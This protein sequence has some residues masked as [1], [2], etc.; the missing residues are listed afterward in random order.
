MC[1]IIVFTKAPHPNQP[2]RQR[3]LFNRLLAELAR[4]EHDGLGMAFV[5]TDNRVHRRRWAT[6]A[7]FRGINTDEL[8]APFCVK[9]CEPAEDIAAKGFVILHGRTATSERGLNNAHPHMMQ[10]PDGTIYALIHNGV[11][12]ANLKDKESLGKL[13]TGCDSELIL[14]AWVAGGM[15]KVSEIITG[16]YAFSVIEAKPDG[17][18]FLHV[19]KDDSASLYASD[20]ADGSYI[21]ATTE[22]LCTMSGGNKIGRV[23]PL[24]HAVFDREGQL[25]D[26]KDIPKPKSSWGGGY[27]YTPPYPSTPAQSTHVHPAAAT[28]VNEE[29]RI[30]EH[31]AKI[32]A[33][34]DEYAKTHHLDE[35]GN[36]IG[37]NLSGGK[38][39][40]LPIE[41][42]ADVGE[43]DSKIAKA[44]KRFETLMATEPSNEKEEDSLEAA[45]LKVASRIARLRKIRAELI[46]NARKKEH[47]AVSAIHGEP[48]SKDQEEAL[49]QAER[50][51][52][53]V[54]SPRDDEPPSD[55]EQA[56][57]VI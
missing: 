43:I 8:S 6:G 16:Y 40:E 57:Q 22:Q 31:N 14:A 11:V 26:V 56:S 1:K 28:D 41:G 25:H 5:G 47:E 48:L 21:F 35:N 42:V 37:P 55:L 45:K 18:Q 46:S 50:D 20:L 49:R 19:V 34:W 39:T 44:K 54:S 38:Q 4:T 36:E 3:A 30:R 24:T 33:Y 52:A 17:S 27:Q 32:D 29:A 2:K 51:A 53:C 23:S 10:G 7:D 13:M 12:N 15:A 9:T